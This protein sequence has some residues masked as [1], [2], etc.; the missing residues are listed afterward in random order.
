MRGRKAEAEAAFLKAIEVAPNAIE[1]R[2]A[3]ANY[4]W[5]IGRMEEVRKDLDYALR[6]DPKHIVANRAMA[7]LQ[8]TT[9]HPEEA[10]TYLKAVVANTT[11]PEARLSLAD[12]YV[13]Q[14]RLADATPLLE[15]LAKHKTSFG[16]ATSRLAGIAYTP[17]RA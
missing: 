12:Y 3:A 13:W 9:G 16:A 11:D 4:Y 1:P 5:S 14:K 6:I 2:L 10:E 8:M 15:E 7:L 17:W